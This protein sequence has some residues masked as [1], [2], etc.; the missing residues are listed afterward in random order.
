MIVSKKVEKAVNEEPL[1]LV[2]ERNAVFFRLSLGFME[3]DNDIAEH[4]FGAAN[5]G[6]GKPSSWGNER[7]SVVLS[8]PRC[9][10]FSARILLSLTKRILSS[11]LWSF[12]R[13]SD[14]FSRLAILC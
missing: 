8:T 7:T 9:W 4:E 13:R 6:D 3:V 11:A 2:I 10:R 12:R 1:Q 14:F 5:G